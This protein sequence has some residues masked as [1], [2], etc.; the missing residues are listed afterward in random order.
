MYDIKNRRLFLKRSL[1]DGLQLHHLF[2]G[3]IINIHSRQLTITDYADDRTSNLLK[4]RMRRSIIDMIHQGDFLICQAKMIRMTSNQASIFYEEHKGTSFFNYLVEFVTSGPVVVMELKGSNAIQKWRTLL[5]PTDSAT[6][7][8]QAPLSVRAKF[9]T[10]NTKNAA[11]GSDSPESANREVD[12]FFGGQIFGGKNTATFSNCTLCIIKP[13]AIIEGLTGK[14]ISAIISKGFEISAVQMF[15]LERAN[16]EEF[17]EVYKGVVNEYKSMVEELCCGPCLAMEIRAPADAPVAFR[18]CV[19]PADPEIAR[20]LRPGTL[21]AMFGKDKIKNAVHCSDLPEDELFSKI[22]TM[23]AGSQWMGL[24]FLWLYQFDRCSSMA[25]DNNQVCVMKS[26]NG[27]DVTKCYDYGWASFGEVISPPNIKGVVVLADPTRACTSV[28]HQSSY[29]QSGYSGMWFLLVDVGDCEFDTKRLFNFCR[30]RSQVASVY[31]AAQRESLLL[32][33][34][35]SSMDLSEKRKLV[36]TGATP[37]K[38]EKI[39][40]KAS[41]S[42]ENATSSSRSPLA[43]TTN[44]EG[45]H[46]YQGAMATEGGFDAAI[47]R[48]LESD[49]VQHIGGDDRKVK[50][51]VVYVGESTGQNLEDNDF[52]KK[53]SSRILLTPQQYPPIWNYEFYMIP[54]AIIVGICFIL[55]AMF[56]ISRYY[57]HYLEQ[58]RNRL[59]PTNLRKI[60]TKK[61]KKGDDYYDVCA[62]CLEEYRDGER[63]RILP[64]EHTYHCKCVDPWLTEG[65]RTCPVCKRPVTNDKKTRNR[66]ADVETAGEST[67]DADETT[68]LIASTSHSAGT[69]NSMTV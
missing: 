19:G 60:P 45:K 46:G 17:H 69:S 48:S 36:P 47:I 1:I 23:K 35:L 38:P 43:T 29:N 9:G 68:P 4:T 31:V 51:P 11:H 5:G 6:A 32:C 44:H 18:E 22:L 57:R 67:N 39:K 3:A 62:I 16:A 34:S 41:E 54:F 10:D 8:T 58:R 30:N 52:R 15:H 50:L 37:K 59:S 55:M 64:C 26:V 24:L 20:H 61:F 53:P 65:K 13:H 49:V 12:F 21:R 40:K 28:K 7:R 63:L 33:D 2:T 27:S 56:M 42:Q 14:I 25:S 66:R